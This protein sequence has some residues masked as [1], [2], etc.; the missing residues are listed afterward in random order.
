MPTG[1]S[2][3][4]VRTS[5]RSPRRAAIKVNHDKY[6]DRLDQAA[7]NLAMSKVIDDATQANT[8][9]YKRMEAISPIARGFGFALDLPKS[10]DAHYA[11]K[12]AK[13]GTAD[14]PI[15]WYKPANS[16]RYRVLYGDLSFKDSTTAPQQVD[17]HPVLKG[18]PP[19]PSNKK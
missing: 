13:P 15:F 17:A 8:T 2:L 14:R 3:I 1:E 7:L 16:P 12:G 18:S 5:G 10:A 19:S 11:G 4:D 9:F 6:P